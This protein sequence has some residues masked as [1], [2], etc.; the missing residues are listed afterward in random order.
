MLIIAFFVGFP[1]ISPLCHF[2][3]CTRRNL[4]Q[5]TSSR[6]ACVN[7]FSSPNHAFTTVVYSKDGKAIQTHSY[8]AIDGG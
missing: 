6:H 2:E 8:R 3:R 7:D 4:L 5:F 1:L